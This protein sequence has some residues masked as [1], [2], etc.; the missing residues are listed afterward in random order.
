METDIQEIQLACFR[1]GE[2]LFAAD[3]MR[4]KEIIRPQR[5]TRLPKAPVFM[6]GVINLRGAVIPVVDLRKRFDLAE[7]CTVEEARLLVVAVARQLVGL[8]VDD[9]TEVVTVQIQDI[10]PAP[11]VVEGIGSEYLIGVCLVK[12]TLIM[13]LNLDRILT[14]R[15]TS[16]LAGISRR[17]EAPLPR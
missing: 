11:Q 6:E 13:L 14:S 12:D 17:A 4:I 8:M 7:A 16:A 3:I 5:L 1:I 2:A 10:K 9:V 15:E